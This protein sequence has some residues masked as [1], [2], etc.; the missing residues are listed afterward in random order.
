MKTMLRTLCVLTLGGALLAQSPLE[1]TFA[2][3]FIVSSTLNPRSQYFDVDITN[4]QGI[5]IT[6]FDVNLST[7]S[8]PS[9]RFD[10]WVT[11]AGG[12]HVGNEMNPGVWSLVSSAMYTRDGGGRQTI[13]L[14]QPFYLA[15]GTYGMT[16]HYDGLN[17]V[18]TNPANQTPPLPPT[19][20]NAD[21]TLDMT[22]ARVRTSLANDPFGGTGNGFSPRHPNIAVHYEVG[23]VSVD[24]VSDVTTGVSPLTVNFTGIGTSGFPGGVLAWQWD[25]DNDGTPDS[26]VQNPTNVFPCG[27][28]TVSL[29]IVDGGGAYTETKMDYIVT[30]IIE[31]G[32]TFAALTGN[33]LQFTDTTT[34]PAQTW[35]WDLNGDGVVDSNQQNPQFTYSAPFCSEVE[36]TLTVT[37]ACQPAET[38]VRGIAIAN[39]LQTRFD[40]NV[41]T[42]SGD[43]RG[44]N[45]F[46]LQVTNPLGVSVCAMHVNTGVAAVGTNV[47][48]NVYLTEGTYDGKTDS[49][50]P[51]TL[52]ASPVAA[53]A[54]SGNQTFVPLGQ[55]LYLAPGNYGVALEHVGGVPR[56]SSIGSTQVF[57]NADLTLT[58][59]A[60]QREPVFSTGTVFDPR[61]VN[62]GLYYTDCGLTSEPGYGWFGAGCPT[63]SGPV[64]EHNVTNLARLGQSLS[65]DVGPLP[66]AAAF[67]L[68]GLSR[69]SS[70]FGPLPASLQPFGAPG[71]TGYVSPDANSLILGLPGGSATFNLNVPN[72]PNLLCQEYYTQTLVLDNGQ[73]GL[74]AVMSHAYAGIVGQ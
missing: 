52:V 70:I 21:L 72:L 7:T 2:G 17:P 13:T 20:S 40:G 16:L 62:L 31:P 4:A 12:S 54:G 19:Y 5:V 46:D 38:L 60:S 71:C 6:K 10:V 18:Y 57:S 58:A 24:F 33:T 49:L 56:Y 47:T 30:D 32:F 43:T 68:F 29:T 55:S 9:G 64:P 34:P 65:V 28:H 73:N 22:S 23:T 36:I 61:I 39:G 74:G 42:S 8:N 44:V 69:T 51:W 35:A 45:Y 63:S 41:I 15:P 11:A 14:T 25:F 67:F 53:S 48:Y 66:D 27:N 37:R 50:D 26:F 3:G 1:S 59:G